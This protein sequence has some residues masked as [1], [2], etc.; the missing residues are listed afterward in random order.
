MTSPPAHLVPLLQIFPSR[1][2]RRARRGR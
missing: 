2:A 1:R